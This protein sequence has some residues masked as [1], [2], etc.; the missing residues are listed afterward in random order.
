VLLSCLALL[1]LSALVGC[2]QERARFSIEEAHAC[3]TNAG[4]PGTFSH[5]SSA[6]A[7]SYDSPGGPAEVIVVFDEDR[8]PEG[9][10]F[11][12]APHG[13]HQELMDAASTIK[14]CTEYG[15]APR[16]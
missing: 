13:S 16:R 5:E 7:Y 10:F 1:L 6:I 2:G 12:S 8:R 14:A 9:T 4:H 11:Q 15:R 3:A